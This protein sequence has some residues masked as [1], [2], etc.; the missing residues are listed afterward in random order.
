MRLTVVGWSGSFPGPDSP[1]SCYLLEHDDTRI[2]LD[3]GNGSLGALQRYADIYAIDAVFIS[4]LHV[5]HCIDLC[6]YHVAR[7]YHPDGAHHRIPV[8]GPKG[9]SERMAA[10]YGLPARP[11]MRDEFNFIRH[12]PA[13]TQ[14][15]PFTIETT[16]VAHP[17]EAY[18]MKVSADG[19]SL[20]YSGDTGPTDALVDL[21]RGADLALFE[22]SFVEHPDNPADLHLTGAEAAD[23]AARAG[24][25][26]LVLT[27]LVAWNDN[28]QVRAE[29]A[30]AYD[31]ELLLASSG[32]QVEV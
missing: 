18:A 15:G 22:A 14:V 31:G 5:D 13:P 1:A 11:G 23:H 21:A 25:G 9:T 30:A 2:L 27:H 32:L 7:K 17:V 19:R 16:R 12:D 28:E 20:V 29:A 10:A 6:S 24:V 26:R 4:H 8:F 3:L